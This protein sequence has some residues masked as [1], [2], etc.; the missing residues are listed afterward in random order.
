MSLWWLNCLD[1]E[2]YDR[3]LQPWFAY[4]NENMVITFRAGSQKVEYFASRYHY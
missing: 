3:V 4:R 1:L 2:S